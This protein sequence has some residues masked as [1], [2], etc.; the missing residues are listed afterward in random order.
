MHTAQMIARRGKAKIQSLSK[1]AM[2]PIFWSCLLCVR[3]KIVFCQVGSNDPI[4]GQRIYKRHLAVTDVP[5]PFEKTDE[6]P[7]TEA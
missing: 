4:I 5:I 3:L 2:F 1:L 6:G 7:S